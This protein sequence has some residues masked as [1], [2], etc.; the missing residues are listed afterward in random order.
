MSDPQAEFL[1]STIGLLAHHLR[2]LAAHVGSIN[3]LL[4]TLD[5]DVI[6]KEALTISEEI[7]DLYASI[8]RVAEALPVPPE[9]GKAH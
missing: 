5:D 9:N 4:M 2:E 7:E 6:T 8:S 1:R 3:A